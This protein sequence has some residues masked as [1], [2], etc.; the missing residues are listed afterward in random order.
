MLAGQATR[1]LR[2]ALVVE[3]HPEL[4]TA[5]VRFLRGRGLHVLEASSSREA[6]SRLA[7]PL[8]LVL[9]DFG[10]PDGPA[11]PLLEATASASPAP[12]VIAMSVVATPE[13]AFRLARFGVHRFLQKPV[14]LADLESAIRAACE[15]GPDLRPMAQRAVG[16]ASLQDVQRR[17]RDAMI[18]EAVALARGNRSRAARLLR[19]SRQAV[20]Q[21]LRGSS[22]PS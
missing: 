7:P 6:I 1:R 2:R 15:E 17:V 9:L 8:D 10:L 11:Y 19:V 21:A 5:L 16:H 14:A 20:Q 13:D 3:D 4:R 22:Q 12:I 18:Q